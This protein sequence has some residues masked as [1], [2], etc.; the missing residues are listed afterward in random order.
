[1]NRIAGRIAAVVAGLCLAA[2]AQA[3]VVISQVYGGGGNSGAT[4]RSDFIELRNNGA[5]AVSVDG[6]SVQYAS[7][8]G[9]TWARTALAGSIAPGGFYLVK[10]ADG[11]GGSVSLPTPDAT[12]TTAMAGTNGKVALVR[13]G[14]ALSGTCPVGTTTVADFVGY[15]SSASCAETAPTAT[16]SNT[17]AALRKGDGS[18]DTGSNSADFATGAPNPRNSGSEPP[19]P[20]EPAVPLSIAQ[21]QGAGLVSAYDGTI[22]VTEGIVTARKFNNGFFLQ[23]ANDDGNAATSEGIFVF[24]GSAP[25]A[26]AAPGN[27]LRVTAKVEEFVPSSNPNQLTITELV[28]PTIEL[29]GSGLALPLA[30]EIGAAELGADATPGTLERL[31]GMRVSVTQSVVIA[32]SGGSIQERTATS[33]SDGVFHVVLPEVARPF[34]EP[35]IGA[36]DVALATLPA[37]KNPPVFDTNPERL[38]VRSRGQIGAAAVSV[39]T[40]AQVAGLI[41]VLDYFAGTWALLPDVG[42]PPAVSG[43]RLPE[44]VNDAAY[45]E[46]TIASFNVLRLFDEVADGNGAV[47]LNADALDKRLTKTAV[48]IC[49]YLK[50]PDILGIVEIEN[51]RVMGMLA[52]RINSSCASAPVYVPYLEPGNDVGGINVGFLVNT[53]AVGLD[54]VRV[55]VLEVRQ[56]GKDTTLAN[57]NGSTSLLNDRPP[58]LLRARVHHDNGGSY[59]VTVIVNHLRSLSGIDDVRSGSNGWS[60]GGERV[61]VKRGAQAAYLAG[62]VESL[63]QAKPDENIVLVGDFNA[64]QFNDGYVDVLGVLTGDPAAPDQVLTHVESPLTSLLIDGSQLEADAGEHYSFV[65]AGNAQT[66]DHVLVNEAVIAATGGLKVDHARINADFG[67][68]NFGDFSVPLRTSDHDPVRL[69]IAVPA[70]RS[71]DLSVVASAAPV[72][73]T[74]GETVS[75]GATMANAGPGAAEFA[76]VALVFDALVAPVVTGAAGWTCLDAVQDAATTTVSC[77]TSSLAAGAT[78][79]F[80]VDVVTPDLPADY[81]LRMTVAARSQTTDPANGDNQAVAQVEVARAIHAD[82]AARFARADVDGARIRLTVE[83]GNAGPDPAAA[84]VLVIEGNARVSSSQFVAPAGWSCGGLD[85][86]GESFRVQCLRNQPAP[87]GVEQF[88]VTLVLPG[89]PVRRVPLS[90]TASVSSPTADRTPENNTATYSRAS[91][92]SGR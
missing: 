46:A 85:S 13:S 84:A 27:L 16:L 91:G 81:T 10:Q 50:A 11:S 61:R 36:L 1:M 87:I 53:R 83:V 3:Q 28:S 26:S 14:T 90:V 41:G 22:V 33:F 78:S 29:L 8:G 7:A 54:A 68:D 64:F 21:I 35:G 69:A 18:I 19:P 25:P 2:S 79:D 43:G 39:D 20:P 45:D 72:A 6:W 49:D 56:F 60:T 31:E 62:L 9:S 55:E 89:L 86:S 66:L 75:F 67:V 48:S 77:T 15:G 40:Q 47:A 59:P 30:V 74:A 71:A 88:D 63:Q 52:E 17:T 24:T 5:S 58:L 42:T 73:V 44:A 70:F 38:M 82:L 4:F 32:A 34:R 23:S 76:A 80:A 65:F 51:L 37:D 12:G 92:K 57:P